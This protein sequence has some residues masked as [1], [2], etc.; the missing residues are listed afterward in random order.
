MT[1][2]SVRSFVV[3]CFAL[4]LAAGTAFAQSL[5]TGWSTKDV[6]AVAATGSATSVNNIFTVAG[7]G[8]DVWGTADEFRFVYKQLAGDGSIVT[9]VS[10]L[11]NLDSWVKA[12]VMMR[13]SLNA[14]ARHAFMMVTP[15]KGLAFQRRT[16]TGGKSTH[17]S[18][19]TGT[20]PYYLKLTRT[21]NTFSA[22]KSR[23]GVTWSLVGS[24]SISMASTIY[25]G[26]AVSSHVDGVLADA[27]FSHTAVA[28][29]VPAVPEPP[30]DG[31]S[32]A[33][34]TMRVLHWNIHHGRA[35]NNV[36]DVDRQ[37]AWM[38]KMN[39]DVVT[40]N[41][42]EKYSGAHGNENQPARFAALLKAK[43]GKTWYY[44][45]AQR[46]GDWS[47]N[48]Q[49]NVVL[50]RFPIKST[51]SL[52]LSCD[53]SAAL[54]TLDVNGRTIT[55]VSTHLDNAS[56]GCRLDEAGDVLAWS[57]GFAGPRIVGGDWNAG[58]IRTEY[59][60]M[61]PTYYD[62]WAKAKASGDAVDY[63]G[64]IRDGA[65]HDYRID[66]VFHTKDTALQL[67][68]A[69]VFDTRDSAGVRA[70]DHKPLVATFTV[71]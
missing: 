21:G 38:A 60:L 23:D 55:V 18:G 59:S 14:N 10:S 71:K 45:F 68:K 69:Q 57:K 11:D 24:Q 62:A 4:T 20:A 58:Q 66:Y 15:G 36:Y 26:V 7:S 56:S 32:T 28:V 5:P 25:I 9:Q 37:A 70:S 31:G 17:T 67:E 61:L 41:E 63:P 50:S 46:Y 47:A 51:A 27:T 48:G 1:N 8:A 13:E 12:G 54:A 40:M 49:G 3:S 30:D 6:G 64:N 42:V 22:R 39:P 2:L 19:G 44:H 33:G 43:T 53:R 34:T 16:T 52:A 35:S 65:T 29:S